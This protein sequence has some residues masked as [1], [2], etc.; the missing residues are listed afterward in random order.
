M[1][2]AWIL[3]LPDPASADVAAVGG[4]GAGLHR[5]VALG[6]RVPAGFVVTTDA[7]RA[8]LGDTGDV[9]APLR[10]L[11]PDA[12]IDAVERAAAQA[13]AR[14]LRSTSTGPVLDAVR[15]A[16]DGLAGGIVRVAVRSSAVGEDAAGASFA[17]EH[18]TFLELR[19]RDAVADAVCRCWAS[20]YTARAV[21]YREHAGAGPAGAMAVVVQEMVPARAAGVFMTLN[22]ANGD[23]STVVCEAVWGLGEPLV[24][25]TVTPDRFVIDKISGEVV[26][27]EVA[28]KERCLLRDPEH[29]GTHETDVPAER[30]E[31]PCL[32]DAELAEILELARRVE[33]DAG[34]PQ[35]GEFAVADPGGPARVHL[36]QT[37]PETVWSTRAPRAAT[38]G[39]RSALSAVLATLTR[40]TSAARPIHEGTP[41]HGG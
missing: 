12:P 5:L 11:P 7:F 9:E 38:D 34:V 39:A 14:L 22:P 6:A 23:R 40:G 30:R 17:G 3:G 20:L 35:D 28:S 15:T 21:S 19:G 16:Y 18:D 29:P 4:K 8:A 26:R 2:G 33:R 1:S 41:D 37:R 36:L 13:R 10:D 27:R 24:S 32:D 31:Q 25:G